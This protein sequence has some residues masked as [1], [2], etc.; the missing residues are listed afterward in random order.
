M[1]GFAGLVSCDPTQPELLESTVSRMN[2]CIRHR[3]P[4]SEATWVDSSCRAAF[5]F[6]RLAI[7]DLSPLADQPMHSE[8]GRYTILYNGETYN[9]DELRLRIGRGPETFRTHCD[10]EVLLACIERLGLEE[11]LSHT[12]GMFAI[13]LWD[14]ERRVLSLARDRLGKKPLHYCSDGSRF[15]FG[16]EIKA[17]LR[18]DSGDRQLSPEAIDAYFSLTY[19]PAPL[20]IFKGIMKVRPG[21]ILEVDE[22]LFVTESAHWSLERFVGLNTGAAVEY[23]EALEQCSAL[24]DDACRR[25]LVSDVPIGVLLSGGVD[26]SLIAHTVAHRLG[27]PLKTFTIGLED[28]AL[29]ELPAAKALAAKIGVENISL[30]LSKQGA[31]EL[32]DTVMNYLDEPFG[33]FSALPTYAV[34][35]LARSEATVLLSGDGGDEVF[36]GYTRYQ[37][38]VGWKKVASWAYSA[39]RRGTLVVG[40]RE[41]AIEIYRRLMSLG[42]VDGG[43]DGSMPAAQFEKL[44]GSEEVRV[45]AL[46][47]LRYIDMKLYL[48]DD[49]LVK[50]DRMSMANSIEL[51][52]PLLDYRLVEFSWK[53]PDSALVHK[54]QR[55][56]ILRE[57]FIRRLGASRLQ[58]KKQGFTLPVADWLVGPLREQMET[59]LTTLRQ[60]DELELYMPRLEQYWKGLLAGDKSLGHQV[61]TIYAFWRWLILWEHRTS[62]D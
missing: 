17:I 28:E 43:A 38:A 39:Y 25:R 6:S 9:A 22:K 31:F 61:W 58:A 52:S 23:S 59:A 54:G 21:H 46:Q 60:R 53:L 27:V 40:Q 57:L 5:A 2:A 34:C 18:V 45:S 8:S 44:L 19:I 16:S 7:Q 32:V 62:W 47:Y 26:S 30:L 15:L 4:D 42:A 13:A 37:W 51:R 29:D 11:T 14:R 41:L 55:K 50:T 36:G 49:I 35:H 20:T 1:C 33:D 56:R 48:P 12:N 10:T 24:M 3:G